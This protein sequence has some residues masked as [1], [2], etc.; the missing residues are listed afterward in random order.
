MVPL[1]FFIL[2]DNLQAVIVNIGLVYQGDILD[3][4]IITLQKLDV[5]LLIFRVFSTIPSLALARCCVKT[6]PFIVG[7]LIL[8]KISSC[9]RRL[10]I[11]SAS[12]LYQPVGNLGFQAA[13]ETSSIASLWYSP[14]DW[15]HVYSVTTV[16]S[17]V[18]VICC[19]SSGFHFWRLG[20]CPCNTILLRLAQLRG[21]AVG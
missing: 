7:K 21:Q 16:D 19:N 8:F 20:A 2:I 1:S 18:E 5:I 10:R 4:S 15:D 17:L 3:A 14:P 9:F 11:R 13:L 6:V 12:L